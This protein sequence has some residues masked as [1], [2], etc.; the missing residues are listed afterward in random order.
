MILLDLGNIFLSIILM[1]LRTLIDA[2]RT[3]IDA[4]RALKDPS[5]YYSLKPLFI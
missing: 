1:A 5:L 4:M 2:M 3:L